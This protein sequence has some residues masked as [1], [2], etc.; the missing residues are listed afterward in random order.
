M[1]SFSQP[2]GSRPSQ[3]NQTNTTHC[4]AGKDKA[5]GLAMIFYSCHE[6][7]SRSRVL[8]T[9]LKLPNLHGSLREP[10]RLW[11]LSYIFIQNENEQEEREDKCDWVSFKPRG[12]MAFAAGDF[13]RNSSEGDPDPPKHNSASQELG[14]CWV[15]GN[16]HRRTC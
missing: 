4:L 6:S 5:A 12:V 15:L 1:L 3:V 10:L 8:R 2:P 9:H 7:E 14:H 11:E 13:S 16:G